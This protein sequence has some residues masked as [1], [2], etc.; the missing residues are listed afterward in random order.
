[1]PSYLWPYIA[2]LG[3]LAI[4]VFGVIALMLSRGLGG[5]A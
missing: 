5:V 1:M 4:A 3:L 2:I